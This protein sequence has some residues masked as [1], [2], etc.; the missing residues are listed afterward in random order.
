M[1]FLNQYQQAGGHA[2]LIGG[3]IMVDQTVLSAKGKAK[4][5][6]I[7]TPSA[8]GLADNDPSPKWQAF[9]KAYKQMPKEGYLENPFGSPSLL[10]ISYYN[11]ADA[12][13]KALDEVK[14]ELSDGNKKFRATL[15][16]TVLDAPNGTIKLDEN[17]QAIGTNFVTEVVK[18]DK[19]E[20]VSKL[21]QTVPNVQQRLG[22]SKAVYDKFIPTDA[23]I[24]PA[25][26]ATT[27]V[28]RQTTIS[29]AR[30][31]V[32][33]FFVETPILAALARNRRAL[34]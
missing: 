32:E 19:G 20:L 29:A 31:A 6:L 24:R 34:N 33:N 23:T 8:S 10:A 22:F 5:A 26:R 15:Q 4:D 1:N 21:V 28:S 25:R 16:N 18:D 17:R 27:E 11:S 2:H 7:G 13:V 30:G 3:S 12:G 14:G 9:V